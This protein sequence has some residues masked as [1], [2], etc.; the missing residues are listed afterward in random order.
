MKTPIELT[1]KFQKKELEYSDLTSAQKKAVIKYLI[2]EQ[3]LT[4]HEASDLMNCHYNTIYY[5]MKT[6][7]EEQALELA[8]K[9]LD[10]YE[11]AAKLKGV[12]EFVK[13][14][15]RDSKDWKLYL[16]AELRFIEKLQSLG[17]LFESPTEVK[18]S[19]EFEFSTVEEYKVLIEIVDEAIQLQSASSDSEDGETKALPKDEVH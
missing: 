1:K 9:G 6:I 18:H 5:Q 2:Q 14:K 19:G 7:R 10:K 15:A 8:T 12:V 4:Y 16:E 13:K 11:I 17:V 3:A